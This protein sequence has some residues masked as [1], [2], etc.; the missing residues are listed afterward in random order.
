MLEGL[1]KRIKLRIK[2]TGSNAA[3]ASLEAGLGKD[4]VRDLLREK[5]DTITVEAAVSLAEALKCNVGWL[6][7]NEGPKL[8][9]SRSLQPKLEVL[10]QELEPEAFDRLFTSLDTILDGHLPKETTR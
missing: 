8:P 10:E 3:R 1:I 7:N 5:K 9:A 6:L 2:E 4:F